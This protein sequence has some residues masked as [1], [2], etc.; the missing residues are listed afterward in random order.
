M[1]WNSKLH[2]LFKSIETIAMIN[3][4]GHLFYYFEIIFEIIE[5]STKAQKWAWAICVVCEI[6]GKWQYNCCFVG[7]CFQDLFKAV[8]SILV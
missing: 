4:Y 6:G 3:N 2:N 8:R 1:R 7:C 5:L